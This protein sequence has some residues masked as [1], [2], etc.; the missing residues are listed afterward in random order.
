M[1]HDKKIYEWFRTEENRKLFYKK[2]TE[3]F[4]VDKIDKYYKYLFMNLNQLDGIK[5]GF[6]TFFI[7]SMKLHA[8]GLHRDLPYLKNL[9]LSLCNI[10]GFFLFGE[11]IDN[12]I[13]LPIEQKIGDKIFRLK[14]VI[15]NFKDMNSRFYLIDSPTPNI[16]ISSYI[17]F[18][19]SE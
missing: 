15:Y 12:Q 16:E 6:P 13:K 8:I 19:V 5:D 17:G 11:S 4:S 14:G 1:L 3:N 9:T 7:G 18:Y 10:K 2:T